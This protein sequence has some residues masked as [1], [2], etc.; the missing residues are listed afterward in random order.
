MQDLGD[1]GLTDQKDADYAALAGC[2]PPRAAD[3]PRRLGAPA[4]ELGGD[5][6][7][8]RQPRVL[9]DEHVP[10]Q[11]RQDEFEQVMAYY[12]ITEAQQYIQSLGFGSRLRAVNNEPQRVRIN[13]WGADNSFATEHKDEIRLGKGGVDDAEDAE[14]VL[15]EYGHADPLRAGL[16]V[17]DRRGRGD[18]RGLRRLL[19]RDR[20]R[21]RPRRLG[22]PASSDPAC[23]A[24]WDAVSYTSTEPHCLRRVDLDL[25]YPEDLRGEVHA[26]GRI[27]SRALWDL[28]GALGR[29]GR[30]HGRSSRGSSASTAGRCRA[31]AEDTVAAARRLYG[32]ATANEGRGGL[33]GP[34]HPRLTRRAGPAGS[35]GPVPAAPGAPAH[36]RIGSRATLHEPRANA[37][38]RRMMTLTIGDTAPD[39]E[40]D[41]TEGK[42]RFH[43]WIGD[44]WAV[45]FSHPKDFTPVCTT[46]L[47]YM[48]RI[49]PE[50]E[51]PEREGHRA[52]RRLDQRPR[53]LGARHRGDAGHAPNYPIIG[54]DDFC[55]LQAVRDARRGRLGRPQGSDRSRQPDGSQRLRDRA[56][57]EG[58]AGPRSTR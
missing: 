58:E 48:A 7:R 13:Q 26:D 5:R 55:D 47:G 54:D 17:L 49:K 3:R 57:Q 24:D 34:G 25:H 18:Q 33:R 30:R 10:L 11:P 23:V 44:S 21:G 22:R 39:F 6:E 15:H 41:T 2:L 43:D 9:A 40:A 56:G 51:Q 46:E 50:F 31:L 19:G 12:W 1:Q 28:R 14:V 20:L 38:R 8:D 45:L 35:A 37:S 32:N 53:G 52:L 36:G 4:R 16:L 42:I 29:E 27:W